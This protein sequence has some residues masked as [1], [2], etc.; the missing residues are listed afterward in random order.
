MTQSCAS[1]SSLVHFTVDF[2][3]YERRGEVT[4]QHQV[5]SPKVKG[6][7]IVGLPGDEAIKAL[8]SGMLAF[9]KVLSILPS[10]QWEEPLRCLCALLDTDAT[11][12]NMLQIWLR[13]LNVDVN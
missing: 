3:V 13:I 1:K 11:E 12:E 6:H 7:C 4:G 2:S 10:E 5:E 9:N 8:D